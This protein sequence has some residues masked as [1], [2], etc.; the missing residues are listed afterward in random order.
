MLLF[1][2]VKL[3]SIVSLCCS[4]CSRYPGYE[5]IEKHTWCSGSDGSDAWGLGY[6]TK[7]DVESCYQAVLEHNSGCGRS[8]AFDYDPSAGGCRCM[9][10]S[11][12]NPECSERNQLSGW[13]TYRVVYGAVIMIML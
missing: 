10:L 8:R 12:N 1:I 5:T 7:N 2:I 9:L 4:V 3:F 6:K 11:G 13:N